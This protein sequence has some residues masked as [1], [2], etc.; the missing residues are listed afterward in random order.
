MKTAA[1]DSSSLCAATASGTSINCT[2]KVGR[3]RSEEYISRATNFP[4]PAIIKEEELTED[5]ARSQ[6]IDAFNAQLLQIADQ[7]E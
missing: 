3:G 5:E 4:G 2:V 6:V 1:V 7:N